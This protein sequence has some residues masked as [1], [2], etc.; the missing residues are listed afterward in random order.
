MSLADKIKARTENA[1]N[2]PK[3]RPAQPP[4]E[5]HKDEVEA[6]NKELDSELDADLEPEVSKE[7]ELTPEQIV[8]RTEDSYEDEIKKLREENAKRRKKEQ[9]AKDRAL[10]M[11]DE[12]FKTERE[13]YESQLAQMKKQLEEVKALK[14]EENKVEADIKKAETSAE[15]DILR[16]ELSELRKEADQIKAEAQ[17]RREAEEQ[18]KSLRKQAAENRFKSMLVEIPEEFKDFASAMFKGYSDPSEGL[19][20]LTKAKAQGLFGKRTIEVVSRVP[21]E[22]NNNNENKVLSGREKREQ[23]ISVLKTRRQGL[24]PGQKL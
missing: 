2:G 20:A 22:T 15:A 17:A 4:I 12:V 16:K 7:E 13:E 5:I 19:I 9:E 18:E 1:G 3:A 11:A 21:R 8:K 23:R 24:T 6:I 14:K 10:A